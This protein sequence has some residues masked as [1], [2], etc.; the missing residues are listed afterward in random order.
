MDRIATTAQSIELRPPEQVLRLER[1]GSM[2]QTRL[3]FMRV[4]LRRF[5]N[6]RW[7]VEKR[8]W[9]VNREG[10]GVAVYSCKGPG[11]EAGS[12]SVSGSASG[13]TYSLVVFSN[14]LDPAKRS[15]RVIAEEWDATFT[16][17]DGVPDESDIRRLQNNV[18]LQEAGRI[19]DKELSLSRANRSVRLFNYVRDELAA[20]RQPDAS[21]LDKVGYLM[22]TTAVYGS[23]KFGAL[24]RRFLVGRKEFASP[25]QCELMAVYMIRM[26]SVDIVEHLALADSPATAV[27]LDKG[28]RKSLGIGNSTGL[29][30]APFVVNHPVLFHHWIVAREKALR[31]VRQVATV[32]KDEIS[33][34]NSLVRRQ[35]GGLVHWNSEHPVQVK[36]VA[37]LEKDLRLLSDCLKAENYL[38]SELP[39]NTLYEWAESSL[40]LEGQECLVTML[41][42]LY[43]DLVDQYASHMSVDEESY[44]KIDGQMKLNELS[45]I[46]RSHYRFAFDLNFE[47]Q[48]SN[49]RFWYAS[50]EKLEPRLGERFEEPGA[51]R[52]HPLA[53]ARDI[54]RLHEA[55]EGKVVEGVDGST[56][57]AEFL[58]LHPEHRHV[59]RR[60]Q[61]VT[62]FPYAEISDNLIAHDMM[63]IDLLRCKLSFFGAIK[64][65][66]RSDRWVR[67]NM[68]QHAPLPEELHCNYDDTWIYPTKFS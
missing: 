55:I 26:F 65:D 28:L 24:D 46:L 51:E 25:F 64:F 4:L 11:G 53:V 17:F 18:P 22:R 42:E 57:V 58:L 14:D 63:P 19:T 13:R 31:D 5:A 68:F 30:M 59:V 1:M 29:G 12:E 47:S 35:L 6:E 10:V 38:T 56:T 21:E 44:F 20:G 36:K 15:D 39:L 50:E 23:G 60:A 37:A 52:E 45:N 34:L 41:I 2:H 61:Q 54:M 48:D 66:P 40:S 67:I 32:T 7:Q 49:A 27:T 16:L 8:H 33:L 43:P 62:V 9:D 3:S